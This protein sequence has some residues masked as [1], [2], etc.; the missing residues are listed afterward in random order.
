LEL[1]EDRCGGRVLAR[2]VRTELDAAAET[3]VARIAARD[4]ASPA[5]DEKRGL[6]VSC[7]DH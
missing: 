3:G 2:L 4:S 1:S 7:L 6:V 5:F